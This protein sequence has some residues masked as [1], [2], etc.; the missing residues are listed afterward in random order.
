MPGIKRLRSVANSFAQHALGG[1]CGA[2]PERTLDERRS[3]VESIRVVLRESGYHCGNHG[4]HDR[5]AD[6]LRRERFDA[7]AVAAAEIVFHFSGQCRTPVR[8]TVLLRLAD[9]N[10]VSGEAG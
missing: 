8:A 1:L 9:G 6:I 3:G 2:S 10:E 4:L 5:L 7:D